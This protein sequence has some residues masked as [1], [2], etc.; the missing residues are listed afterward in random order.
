MDEEIELIKLLMFGYGYS[1]IK[2]TEFETYYTN[3]DD[4]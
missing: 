4:K 1:E 2:D 3:K